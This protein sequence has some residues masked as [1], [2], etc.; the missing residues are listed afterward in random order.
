MALL[1]RALARHHWPRP[2]RLLSVRRWR[3]R[4]CV[5]PRAS[6]DT[7]DALLFQVCLRVARLC[8]AACGLLLQHLVSGLHRD[9]ALCFSSAVSYYKAYPHQN[10]STRSLLR[11]SRETTTNHEP[12]LLLYVKRPLPSRTPALPNILHCAL[13]CHKAVLSTRCSRVPSASAS[14]AHLG[15][16]NAISRHTKRR[17]DRSQH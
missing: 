15:A 12:V 13:R 6:P 3:R 2:A 16:N 1:L 8:P 11:P 5:A 17:I 7:R 10:R 4:A 9:F 14:A